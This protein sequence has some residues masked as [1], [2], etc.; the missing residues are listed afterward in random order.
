MRLPEGF[1]GCVVIF[2]KL[3]LMA[4][5]TPRT[6]GLGPSSWNGEQSDPYHEEEK[7]ARPASERE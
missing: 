1:E 7:R 2:P 6:R 5:L 4:P 3:G